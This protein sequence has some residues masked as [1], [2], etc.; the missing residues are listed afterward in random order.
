MTE[1]ELKTGIIRHIRSYNK[2]LF[3]DFLNH[4]SI[5][6]LLCEI[7]PLYEEYFLKTN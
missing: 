7:H 6:E 1:T 3:T 5:D 2:K 4:L